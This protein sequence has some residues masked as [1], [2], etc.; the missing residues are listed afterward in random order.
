MKI[1]LSFDDL[2]ALM[3]I[4]AFAGNYATPPGVVFSYA[5]LDLGKE[6]VFEKV[7][8]LFPLLLAVTTGHTEPS[9]AA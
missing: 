1:E 2:G 6:E 7:T 3:D 5:N 4:I 8:R 9:D